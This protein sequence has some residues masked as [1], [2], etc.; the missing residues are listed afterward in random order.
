MIKE[1]AI[2]QADMASKVWK[3]QMLSYQVEAELLRISDFPPLRERESDL[4]LS[5]ETFYGYFHDQVLAGVISINCNRQIIDI[6]RLMIHPDYFRKGIATQLLT[7]ILSLYQEAQLIK[8]STALDNK[9]AVNA[10]LKQGFKQMKKTYMPEGLWIVSFE[11]KLP[12]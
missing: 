4:Q 11:K 9:P 5:D 8:V 7:V 12:Y 6:T 3:L 1:I 2:D 10:Y